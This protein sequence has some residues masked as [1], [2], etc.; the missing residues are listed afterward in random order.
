MPSRFAW[1]RRF[2]LM[3]HWWF[4]IGW[5]CVALHVSN[6]DAVVRVDALRMPPLGDT[7][8]AKN[9]ATRS[10]AQVAVVAL[11]ESNPAKT[12]LQDEA[13][14]RQIGIARSVEPLA[15]ADQTK[16]LLRWTPLPTGGHAAAL[17]LQVPGAWGARL[18]VRFHALP[19]A[20]VFRLY[21]G[22]HGAMVHEVTGAALLERL[23]P[24]PASGDRTWWTP[25][26]GPAPVLEMLLPPGVGVDA[27]GMSIPQLSEI[28]VPPADLVADAQ[29]A[30][31]ALLKQQSN[32]CQQDVNCQSTLLELRDAVVRMVYVNAAK[33]FQCTGTLLNN[34]RQD[35]TPYVLT[36]AHCAKDQATASTLQTSWFY[37]TQSCSSTQVF[38]GHAERYGGARW[39]ASSLV[40]DMTLLELRDT[41]P[42][43][44]LF[45][46]WD[47]TPQPVG[48]AVS[49]IHHPRGDFQK[50]NRGVLKENAACSVDYQNH[51]L[52]CE[53]AAQEEGRFYR[54]ALSTGSIEPGSSGSAM[55]V[56]GRVAGTLTG[57]DAWC[58]STGA[59]VVYGRL[60]QALQSTFHPW[61]GLVAPGSVVKLP[62]FQFRILQSGAVFYTI[63]A[64]ERDEVITALA[65]FVEY[66]GVAFGAAAE[67]YAQ[68]V[69]VHRFFNPQVVAHFYTAGEAESQY[70][71]ATYPQLRYEG[72]AWWSP[73]QLEE[74][75][76]SVYRFYRYSTQSHR[77]TLDAA[78][79]DTWSS[80][81]DYAYEGLAYYVWAAPSPTP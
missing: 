52:L 63:S 69:A 49:A 8:S 29:V 68:G 32:N 62:V 79:R 18:G 2:G 15:S 78:Q 54:I 12:A 30:G 23:R 51:V 37:Y 58:P 1:A 27:L 39:L 28:V 4:V 57:G 81:V 77:Y 55:F 22:E 47:A 24:D 20:A 10:A 11:A 3:G 56:N 9:S 71:Q 67:P 7:A 31:Q 36:V 73:A 53:D 13:G 43:G 35:R 26:I 34:A 74:G 48:Q 44:A 61:L 38:T 70:V 42:A 41:P 65:G 80:D 33:T 72:V 19:A 5:A 64:Q 16:G 25:D 6:A 45:A 50:F 46:G 14:V 60:D 17:Q 76:Q 59:Q 40:N 66:E 75:A 21:A